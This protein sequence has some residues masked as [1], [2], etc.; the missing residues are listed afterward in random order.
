ML[1]GDKDIRDEAAGT[2]VTKPDGPKQFSK[3]A[4]VKFEDDEEDI[5]EAAEK[6]RRR[7]E[8]VPRDADGFSEAVKKAGELKVTVV[9]TTTKRMRMMEV[10]LMDNN[11]ADHEH[12]C[13]DNHIGDG[14]FYCFG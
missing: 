7:N 2:P 11:D 3:L 14:A 4:D 9:M 5:A 1:Q 10:V 6:Q 13:D 12:D 8:G